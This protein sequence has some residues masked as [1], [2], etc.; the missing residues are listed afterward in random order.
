M[1]VLVC[2]ITVVFLGP[3]TIDTSIGITVE[4]RINIA[5]H[6]LEIKGPF[7]I[8]NKYTQDIED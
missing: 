8:L 3:V 7:K 1:Y 6:E 4:N 5:H 2:S